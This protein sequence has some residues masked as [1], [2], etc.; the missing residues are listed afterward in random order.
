MSTNAKISIAGHRGLGKPVI[1]MLFLAAG[2]S[3]K[4]VAHRF[5]RICSFSSFRRKS[6]TTFARSLIIQS[7]ELLT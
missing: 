7:I 3:P 4:D 6:V 1:S 2:L 5:H